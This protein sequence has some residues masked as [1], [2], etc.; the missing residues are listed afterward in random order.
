MQHEIPNCVKVAYE[1]E[2]YELRDVFLHEHS[3]RYWKEFL[4]NGFVD[5]W[6]MLKETYFL[7]R[8]SFQKFFELPIW[9]I[10]YITLAMDDDSMHFFLMCGDK[11]VF[12]V[13][14][15]QGIW[16][17]LNKNPNDLKLGM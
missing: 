5:H 1:A 8:I 9:A 13:I 12:D 17:S 3:L 14:N 16:K 11:E 2:R 4:G 6:E 10:K 7:R 15:I